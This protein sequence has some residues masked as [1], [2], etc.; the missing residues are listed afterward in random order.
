VTRDLFGAEFWR[1]ALLDPPWAERGGG[2]I[3]RG[4][5][6]HY[7]TLGKPGDVEPIRRVV[8]DSGL[9]TP[10]ENA[11]AWCWYTDNFLPDALELVRLLGF[12]YVRTFQW[13]KTRRA[14]GPDDILDADELDAELRMGI[15]QYA[16]GCHEGLLF[17]V[18]GHGQDPE[19][20][21]GARAARS[22]FHAP[23]VLD[24][25]GRRKHSA[26]PPKSYNVIERIS[27]GPC[28]EFFAR[29]GREGWTSWGNQAPA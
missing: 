15:G 24:E 8:V 4:C 12:R 9:W 21:T 13:V 3:K 28:I 17:A 29:S 5:D 19:V 2:K 7:G 11:H 23:H 14:F 20:W 22:V 27:R 16:R 10:A 25:H 6:R 26:K 1:C 18:R